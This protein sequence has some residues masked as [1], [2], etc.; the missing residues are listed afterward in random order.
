VSLAGVMEFMGH[1]DAAAPLALGVYGHVTEQTLEDARNAIDRTLFRL[2]PVRS[3]DAPVRG[4][5]R[6]VVRVHAASLSAQERSS[7]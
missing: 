1:S 6:E 7:T 2:R 4:R 3:G 5:D